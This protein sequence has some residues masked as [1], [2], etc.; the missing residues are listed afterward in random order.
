M[1]KPVTLIFVIEIEGTFL[2]IWKIHSQ[3][4]SAWEG[5]GGILTK[6]G[7]Q[8]RL[9]TSPLLLNTVLQVLARAIR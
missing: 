1:K 6:L 9:P 8:T 2:N 7:N 3:H 5:V 4:Q